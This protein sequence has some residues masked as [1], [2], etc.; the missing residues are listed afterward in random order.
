ML[1]PLREL[2]TYEPARGPQEIC[3]EN[4]QRVVLVAANL[5]GA[6]ISQVVP[7]IRA[8]IRE[9]PVPASYQIA[10]GSEQAEMN[11]SF[12]SLWL[13]LALA[14]LLTYMIM[15]A[16]FESLTHPFLVLLTLPMGAAGAFFALFVTGQTLNIISIIGLVV[17]VGL[18]VD[19]AIVEIDCMNQ[20]RKAGM[21]LREAVER[22]CR[23]RLRPIL[24]ASLTTVFGLVPMALGLERGAEL[25]Q[26]LGIVVLAGLLCSTFLTLILIPVVYEWVENRREKA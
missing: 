26:P 24:M 10:F 25:L 9:I 17:L 21:P 2:V 3:R 23:V 6:K 18:V 11:A 8:K 14:I 20:L 22:A 1:I 5:K 15:A 4:Q 19:D 12:K 7:A 13:A 16:Q